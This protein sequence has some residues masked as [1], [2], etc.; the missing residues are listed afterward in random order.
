MGGGGW[1]GVSRLGFVSY[2]RS[3]TQ[4]L[5]ALFTRA[6]YEEQAGADVKKNESLAVFH[7]LRFGADHCELLDSDIHQNF[8]NGDDQTTQE[9]IT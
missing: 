2:G 4:R 6:R 5:H 9:S 8:R 7:P 3:T 1:I